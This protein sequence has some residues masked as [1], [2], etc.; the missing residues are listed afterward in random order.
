ML[1]WQ[2]QLPELVPTS[3]SHKIRMGELYLKSNTR[4][5]LNLYRYDRS[6]LRLSGLFGIIF[7]T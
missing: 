1:F 5:K 6:L 2:L 3:G 7:V 4:V